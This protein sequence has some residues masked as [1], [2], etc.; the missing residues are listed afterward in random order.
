MRSKKITNLPYPWQRRIYFI[1]FLVCVLALVGVGILSLTSENVP[2]AWLT[3]GLPFDEEHS[4]AAGS[5]VRPAPDVSSKEAMHNEREQ[6]LDAGTPADEAEP[7]SVASVS[8]SPAAAGSVPAR[9]D[10]PNAP[11]SQ[12]DALSQQAAY[13]PPSKPGPARRA[14]VESDAPR[15][16]RVTPGAPETGVGEITILA[17]DPGVRVNVAEYVVTEAPTTLRVPWPAHYEVA[18]QMGDTTVYETQV[19]LTAEN[20]RFSLAVNAEP[21]VH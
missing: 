7:P 10:A 19:L 3:Q 15:R 6:R 18:F 20:N 2:E 8:A 9:P 5:R 17:L 11:A 14:A 12:A 4:G 13:G 16:P 1:G 21:G